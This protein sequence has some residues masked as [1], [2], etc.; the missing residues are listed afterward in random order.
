MKVL[1]ISRGFPNKTDTIYG[2]FEADQ[3][4]AVQA[5]GIQPIFLCIDRRFHAPKGRKWGITKEVIEDII[6][7][8]L[9][10]CPL[11][12]NFCL[13]LTTCLAILFGRYLF[14]RIIKENGLPDI[15]H[16]HYLF[17]IPIAVDLGEK[18]K[19]PIVA[20]E[21]WSVVNGNKKPSDVIFLMKKY[22]KTID[23]LISVSDSFKMEIFKV[24]GVDS[25]VVNNIVDTSYYYYTE[26][27]LHNNS[28]FRFVS[29]G[30]LIKRK[31][32]NI[33]I[34]AFK[35][36]DDLPIQ[37]TIVGDGPEKK[38]LQQLID[39]YELHEKV[40]L[41]GTKCRDEIRNIFRNSKC[42][43]LPSYNETFGVVY[44]EAL[45]SG[46]PVIATSCGGPE[47][48]ITKEDGI[49]IPINNIQALVD[50]LKDMFLNINVYDKKKISE[51]CISK[52]SSEVIG[53]Q[54][55]QVYKSIKQ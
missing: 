35:E 34:E 5:K 30:S 51:R 46:L 54:I 45:A 23:S 26:S 42:F 53:N 52:F 21:H 10:I 8:R 22:Y 19:I 17:N 18:Y 27:F 40:E 39:K 2:S 12:I 6:I 47:T 33:L 13:R 36:L 3:A 11:P 28:I 24:V 16:A 31:G 32:F 4:K 15:I 48:F 7:Y 50:A 20:T 38:N 37:L 14:K 41:V 1:F 9:F 43:V 49:L 25:I 44:I 29:I 55:M